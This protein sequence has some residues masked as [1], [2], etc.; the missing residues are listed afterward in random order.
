MKQPAVEG[1]LRVNLRNLFG[2]VP[3]DVRRP[4]R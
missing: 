2:D 4:S 1:E 3:P